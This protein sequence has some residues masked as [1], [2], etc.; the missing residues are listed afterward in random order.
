MKRVPIQMIVGDKDTEEVMY[1]KPVM[2]KLAAAA[3]GEDVLLAIMGRNRVQRMQ[4]LYEN[5]KQTGLN[6][7]LQVVPG[8]GH[9]GN[10][11]VANALDFFA[12]VI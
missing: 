1:S 4:L 8:L 2:E 11:V 7:K 5:W 3:G 9:D 6:V 10:A 12:S